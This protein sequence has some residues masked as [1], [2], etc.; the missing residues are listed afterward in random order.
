MREEKYSFLDI[1][2][3]IFT[4][5]SLVNFGYQLIFI[6]L[7]YAIIFPFVLLYKILKYL[8]TYDKSKQEVK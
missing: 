6:R 8:F 3:H 5:K 7:F 1:I 2:K 4:H